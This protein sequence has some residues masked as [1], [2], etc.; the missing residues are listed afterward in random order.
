MQHLYFLLVSVIWGTSFVFM[1][2]ASLA[3]GPITIAALGTLGGGLIIG[4]VWL[5]RR[6]H[7]PSLWR[8]VPALL[9]MVVSGYIWP[10]V[11]Q[12][13][14]ISRAGHGY[15]ASFVCLVPLITIILSVPFL[16][17]QPTR[18][19]L[20]GVLLG[21]AFLL[22][23]MW[24]GLN[25]NVPL[26]YLLLA[27]TV[28]TGYAISNCSLKRW[29]SDVPAVPLA[30]I[31]MF[32]SGIVLWPFAMTMESV[33]HDTDFATALGAMSLLAL[34]SRGAGVVL[35]YTLIR[36]RGPLFASMVTYMIPVVALT[37]SWLD[38]ELITGGQ[39]A[40]VI[41]VLAMVS[42]V[43]RDIERLARTEA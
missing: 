25:R 21:L 13:Y 43:Q 10:F 14:L 3:F 19:Q 42:I 30:C 23:Y 4:L 41:C 38:D 39:L 32:I 12:P 5:I 6:T 8:R 36:R 24:D 27:I 40:A 31:G 11:I 37:W 2:R 26:A 28:P 15:I 17:Q 16:R 7:C 9:L 33:N 29:L 34:L 18:V 20:L 22:G 1:D 35:F